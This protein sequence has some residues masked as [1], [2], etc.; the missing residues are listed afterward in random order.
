MLLCA[1]LASC[2][3]SAPEP[4]PDQTL[5]PSITESSPM[6]TARPGNPACRLLTK[7]ERS[8]LVG[9]SMDAEVPVRPELGSEECVWVHSLQESNSAA[10]R[11]VALSGDV[12]SRTLR[13]QL[14]YH[15]HR[16]T[17]SKA[18]A[19]KLEKAWTDLGKTGGR[20]ADDQVCPTYLM[21]IEARGGIKSDETV[22][23][24]SIGSRTAAY[25]MS[26]KDGNMIVA[27]YGEHGIGPSIALQNGVRRLLAAAEERSDDVF[28]A[29]AAETG[30]SGSGDDDTNGTGE[31][32]PGD[33]DEDASPSPEPSPSE[34]DESEDEDES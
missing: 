8:D 25:A 26:C 16:P 31:P 33:T 34:T 5:E 28:A 9:Y 7:K 19:K 3:R 22:F 23:Y 32:T 14:S 27:G 1:A 24:S 15:L 10:I 2:T 17:T 13:P 4:H 21:L 6:P 11:V 12:W 18:L 30:K 29:I 20:L